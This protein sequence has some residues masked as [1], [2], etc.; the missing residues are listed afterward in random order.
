MPQQNVNSCC[1]NIWVSLYLSKITSCYQKIYSKLVFEALHLRQ[2]QACANNKTTG[3]G[4]VTIWIRA[5]FVFND[6]Q[7]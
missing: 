1:Q 5:F 4:I 6:E 2:Q 3:S 7:H